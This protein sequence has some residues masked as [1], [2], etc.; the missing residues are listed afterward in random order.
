MPQESAISRLERPAASHH[1][2]RSF[3]FLSAMRTECT[4]SRTSLQALSVTDSRYNRI[5]DLG[6]R[7]KRVMDLR[8]VGVA[9]LARRTGY[10][11]T[12]LYDVLRGDHA[13]KGLHKIADA[14]GAN[15]RYLESGTGPELASQ[16]GDESPYGGHLVPLFNVSGSM[17]TGSDVPDH[18]E[19]VRNI[20]LDISEL[21]KV[22]S[23]S[24]PKNLSFITGYGNSMEPTFADGD[25]LLIDQGITDV[26]FEAV[27]ALEKGD[28]LFIKR[29]QRRTDGTLLMLSDNK[30][31]EPQTISKADLPTFRVRGRVVL[32]WN[33]R[34]V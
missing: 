1:E 31:Y 7:I 24:N 3:Q 17:G 33:A 6:G 22:A 30:L 27:Y 11:R 14:L 8:D 13:P 15:I 23:F 20:S 9:E 12:T 28:E 32:V 34:K 2:I 21:R 5:M 4:D 19:L 26:R 10:A 25:T 16:N 18:I 29:I